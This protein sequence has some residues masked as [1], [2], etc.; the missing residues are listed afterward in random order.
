MFSMANQLSISVISKKVPAIKTVVN[1]GSADGST[2]AE[3][4]FAGCSLFYKTNK[5]KPCPNKG[6]DSITNA[7][8]TII[9]LRINNTFPY[10]FFVKK[11]EPWDIPLGLP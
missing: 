2:F 11:D 3:I 6:F 4:I 10:Y 7:A 5:V 9:F 8:G 1:A